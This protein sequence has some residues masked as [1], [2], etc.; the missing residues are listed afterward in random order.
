MN[1]QK[2]TKGGKDIPAVAAP[3]RKTRARHKLRETETQAR[4]NKLS[5]DVVGIT[6][7]K[8]QDGNQ[9]KHRFAVCDPGARRPHIIYIGNQNTYERNYETK[10]IE[11]MEMRERFVDDHRKRKQEEEE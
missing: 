2:K 6:H 7:Y 8:V 1:T 4:S 11:A 3:Q 9:T 5:C 10:L